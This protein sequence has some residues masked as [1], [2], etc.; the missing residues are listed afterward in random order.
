MG[1]RRWNFGGA[2]LQEGGKR[3]EVTKARREVLYYL[4]REIGVTMADI[5]RNVR[6]GA[7]AVAMALKQKEA[8][9]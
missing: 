2:K 8:E 6:V 7:S 1:L 9:E 4:S 5:A 3:R